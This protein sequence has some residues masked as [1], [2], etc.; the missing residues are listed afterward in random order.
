MAD[1]TLAPLEKWAVPR[2]LRGEVGINVVYGLHRRDTGERWDGSYSFAPIRDAEGEITGTVVVGR[3]ITTQKAAQEGWERMRLLMAEGERIAHLGTREYIVATKETIWSD[4]EC[5]IYGVDPGAPSPGYGE[6]LR[7][8]ILPDD[9]ERLNR[10]WARASGTAP[11][12]IGASDRTPGRHG[13]GGER[14]RLSVLRS[15]WTAPQ[16]RRHH[17]G[18]HR[19]QGARAGAS[20]RAGATAQKRAALAVCAGRRQAGRLGLG[21]AARH[22]LLLA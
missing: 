2:A 11:L 8:S 15:G 3:D 14:P 9:A 22:R 20:R 5:R 18:W 6:M 13:T 16:V 12:R 21:H 7:Q 17:A 10:T 19:E 1:G 4:A